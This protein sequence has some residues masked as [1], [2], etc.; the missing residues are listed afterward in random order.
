MSPKTTN[1]YFQI[2]DDLI[3]LQK[4][5]Y[6]F[7]RDNFKLWNKMGQISEYG[8]TYPIIENHYSY[9]FDD[10]KNIINPRTNKDIYVKEESLP[11]YCKSIYVDTFLNI[12]DENYFVAYL[13]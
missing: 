5:C 11:P 7:I 6:V 8:K 4:T 10:N 1:D 3:K 13:V 12:I 2:I 9:F